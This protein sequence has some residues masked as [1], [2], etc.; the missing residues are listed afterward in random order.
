MTAKHTAADK[1]QAPGADAAAGSAAA[2]DTGEKRAGNAGETHWSQ[3]TGDGLQ[4]PVPKQPN[5]RD[6]SSSSQ[7]AGTASMQDI[8]ELAHQDAV[9]SKDTDRGPVLD[10]VYNGPVTGGHRVGDEEKVDGPRDPAKS[11][12]SRNP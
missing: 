12:S 5:E 10:A 3:A 2:P 6:E 7:S 4:K 11:T 8:G 9:N 1:A